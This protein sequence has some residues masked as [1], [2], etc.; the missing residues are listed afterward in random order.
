MNI[1]FWA[2]T[3]KAASVQAAQLQEVN[4]NLARASLDKCTSCRQPVRAVPVLHPG[5]RP[6]GSQIFLDVQKASTAEGQKKSDL[7][8]KV[9]TRSLVRCKCLL[10]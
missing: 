2:V 1:V 9:A 10:H 8:G 6:H 5:Q 4:T 3:V 7:L